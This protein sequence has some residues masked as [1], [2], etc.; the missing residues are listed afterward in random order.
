MENSE[1][2]LRRLKTIEGHLRGV[3]RMVEAD[4]YC[5]DVIRQIQAVESALNKV[6]SQ[7][8]EN[9]LNSC[10]ITAIQGNDKKERERVLKEITEVFD[11][12]TKV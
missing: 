8:L 7:I 12:S 11:M 2:T 4:E 10:V 1:N 9:H 3:I 6:S 5:I